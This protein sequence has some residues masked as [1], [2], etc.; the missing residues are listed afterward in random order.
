ME[1]VY[2]QVGKDIYSSSFPICLFEGVGVRGGGTEKG[3]EHHKI[4]SPNR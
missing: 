3:L 1:I 4:Y 2:Y